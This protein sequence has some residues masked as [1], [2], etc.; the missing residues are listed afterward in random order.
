MLVKIWY[1]EYWIRNRNI[2]YSECGQSAVTPTERKVE[3]ER[4]REYHDDEDLL[5]IQ[6]ILRMGEL[7]TYGCL[8]AAVSARCC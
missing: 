5:P 2:V 4:E 7:N 3:K 8:V 1:R 6:S